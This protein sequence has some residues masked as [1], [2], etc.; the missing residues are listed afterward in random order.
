MNTFYKLFGIKKKFIIQKCI[1]GK[2]IIIKLPIYE[3]YSA[4]KNCECGSI[5][6]VN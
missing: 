3:Y 6:I 4:Q 5:L 2:K 1:C